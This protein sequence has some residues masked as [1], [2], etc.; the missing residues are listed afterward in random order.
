MKRTSAAISFRMLV[1]SERSERQRDL[2]PAA[3]RRRKVGERGRKHIFSGDTSEKTKTCAAALLFQ[4]F[5]TSEGVAH[6][7]PFRE[8]LI[9]YFAVCSGGAVKQND[10]SVVN[11]RYKL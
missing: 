3:R 4:L 10:S 8:Q 5:K 11:T 6:V 9:E 7:L 2:T 1:L